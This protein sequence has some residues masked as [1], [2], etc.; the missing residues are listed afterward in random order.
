L[1]IAEIFLKLESGVFALTFD[2]DEEREREEE[3]QEE[4]TND[5]DEDD[6]PDRELRIGR[7]IA[8]RVKVGARSENVVV[9]SASTQTLSPV[10]FVLGF[11]IL[12]RARIRV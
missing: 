7:G 10:I 12:H 4:E 1:K 5:D 9:S 3:D 8:I 2:E 11:A 6:G